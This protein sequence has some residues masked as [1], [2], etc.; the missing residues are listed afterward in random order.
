MAKFEVGKKYWTRSVCDHETIIPITVEKR[1]AKTLTTTE[2]KTLRISVYN[3]VEQ[4]K[5]WGTYSMCPIIGA[6]K[7]MTNG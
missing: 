5:P 6:D 7:V 4:V 1:T 3:D 2:G